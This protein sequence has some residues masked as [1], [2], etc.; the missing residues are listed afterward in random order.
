MNIAVKIFKTNTSKLNAATYKKDYIPYQV[1]LIPEMQ[2]WFINHKS[3]NVIHHILNMRAINK[4]ILY[5]QMYL[6]QT[7]KYTRIKTFIVAPCVTP[8]T[9]QPKICYEKL[10]KPM[11]KNPQY[12]MILQNHAAIANKNVPPSLLAWKDFLDI[13][14][15]KK[16][17]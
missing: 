7:D 11:F 15:S 14:L 3:F 10:N 1:G 13:Q 17:R 2:G 8:K 12:F 9:G 4:A 6:M 16:G 5:L